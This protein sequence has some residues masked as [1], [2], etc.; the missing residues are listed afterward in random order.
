VE[1]VVATEAGVALAALRVEDPELRPSSRRAVPVAGDGHLRP[2]ADDVAPEPDPRSPGELEPDA[3]RLDDGGRQAGSQTRWLEGDEECLGAAGQGGEAAQP[4][5]DPGGGRARV[6][7]YRQVDDQEVDRPTGQQGS[8]DRQAFVDRVGGQDEEPVEPDTAGNGLDR[9][10]GSGQVEP[11][12]DRPVDLG[13]CREPEG[14]GRLAG[15]GIAAERDAR[16]ARQATRPE[17][18]VECRK[19]GPDDPL[20]SAT[21]RYP[22]V[23]RRLRD[24]LGRERGHRQRAVDPRGR[25]GPLPGYPRSCRAPA[26][27]EGRQSSRHVR[28]KRRHRRHDRTDVLFFQSPRRTFA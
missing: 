2:L 24:F 5:R 10:E 15:A 9:V 6:R 12:D 22:G 21:G 23:R 20:N 28:G 11:G 19:A 14:E 8:G 27:L 4:I 26:H 13:L 25:P 3:G 1:E 16:A 18:G 7:P 17:D